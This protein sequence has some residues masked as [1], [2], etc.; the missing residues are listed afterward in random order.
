MPRQKKMDK[1]HLLYPPTF[2]KATSTDT[3]FND[4]IILNVMYRYY[5]S[6]S[7]Q[8]ALCV[9]V[10]VC[11]CVYVCVCVCVCVYI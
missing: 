4:I 7:M 10:C 8:E 11:V 1:C 2:A 6:V 9:C 3:I 5:D